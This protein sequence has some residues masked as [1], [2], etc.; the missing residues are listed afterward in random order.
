MYIPFPFLHMR[1]T[2]REIVVT[3]VSTHSWALEFIL[4]CLCE[5]I[6]FLLPQPAC[7]HMMCKHARI[8]YTPN[9]SFWVFEAELKPNPTLWRKYGISYSFSMRSLAVMLWRTFTSVCDDSHCRL[10]RQLNLSDDAAAA[11]TN[12]VSQRCDTNAAQTTT[13][14][15]VTR[16]VL[17]C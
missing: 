8:I 2:S 13:W 10:L 6:F 17:L 16:W 11:A 9:C 1:R 5:L 7:V 14:L 15:N 12:H 3:L 4:F